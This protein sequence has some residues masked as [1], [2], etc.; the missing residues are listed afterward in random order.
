MFVLC[1]VGSL[2]SS[3]GSLS[4]DDSYAVDNVDKNLELIIYY[5]QAKSADPRMCATLLLPRFTHLVI[6]LTLCRGIL[7]II[8][9]FIFFFI[10]ISYLLDIVLML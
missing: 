10:L 3:V 1:F 5:M 9:Q 2:V 8:P 7:V 6:L 4:N